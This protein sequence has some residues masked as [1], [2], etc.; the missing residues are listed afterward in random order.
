ME[1]VIEDADLRR[2]LIR[3]GF[4]AAREQTLDRFIAAAMKQLNETAPAESAAVSKKSSWTLRVL[5][6]L[7]LHFITVATSSLP[8]LRPVLRLRGFLLKPAFKSCGKN[9]QCAR[10]VT[11]NFPNRLEIGRDV[12]IAT[13]CWLHAWGGMVLEDEV[14]LGPY[15]VL[16]TGD[17]TPIDGSY[18]FGPSDLAPI[19][20]CRG[21]WVA[22]HAT[23]IKGVIIGRGALLA[24]NSVATRD[25]PPFVM[26][27]GVPAQV[28]PEG[29]ADRSTPL[30]ECIAPE[31][32]TINHH[33]PYTDTLV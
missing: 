10:N 13:G 33:V 23:V 20:I 15:A 5:Q 9:F 28:I 24:A 11:I 31:N 29:V 1:R 3:N 4:I 8:D 16:V 26:A 25:I 27:G 17:H 32:G 22:A 12:Y 21:A 19:R 2:E 6:H 18:R 30:N 14:Q 7:W